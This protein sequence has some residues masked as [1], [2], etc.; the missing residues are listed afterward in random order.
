MTPNYFEF[1]ELPET[2]QP[3]EAALKRRYYALSREYHP[4]FHATESPSAN[5]KF[6]NWPRSTPT[7]TAPSPILTSE[8]P[9]F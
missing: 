9:T 4:D 2:F 1:Y 3:D 5:R 7:P 6:C 8:W